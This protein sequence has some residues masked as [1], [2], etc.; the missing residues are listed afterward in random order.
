M[1]AQTFLVAAMQQGAGTRSG[2]LPTVDSPRDWPAV[3]D[4]AVQ[5]RIAPLVYQALAGAP[6]G[7]VPEYVVTQ[8][9]ERMR[10]S[11]GA[12]MLCEHRLLE[13]LELL[14]LHDIEALVL[15]GAGLAHTLYPVP[16]LR[17]YHDLDIV[18][19]ITDHPRLYQVLLN[20]GY[21]R[22]EESEQAQVEGQT[23]P[24]HTFM[25]PSGCLEI[26]VHADVLQLGLRN[27]HFDE[28]WREART[29]TCES[30]RMRVLAPAHQ[31]L[32]LASHAHAHCYSRLLWLNDL[33]LFIRRYGDELDW[34]YVTYLARD[35]GMGVI[36]RHALR[37]VHVVLGTPLPEL[38]APTTA[39]RIMGACYRMLWPQA[40]VTRLE[41]REHLRLLRFRPETG[42]L[43]ETLY[44]FFLLGRRS[45]KWR[46]LR[47]HWQLG[48]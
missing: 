7:T 25:D 28:Y 39:E 12:R 5:H 35:E 44:G 30:L 21:Q 15:K 24:V 27:R 20:A 23:I 1:K 19:R 11:E 4:L 43:R 18:C 31:I 36:L 9:D 3:V 37:V 17:P 8:L 48:W 42:D 32:H 34:Q 45:E 38:P 47:R 2:P 41:R 46:I 29:L 14:S 13:L 26:E 40:A 22:E 16:E 6:E 33:D 10:W